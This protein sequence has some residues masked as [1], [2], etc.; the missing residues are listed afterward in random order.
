MQKLNID[1]NSDWEQQLAE[2]IINKYSK[3][4]GELEKKQKRYFRNFKK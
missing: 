4:Y 2:L 1:I 3:Y